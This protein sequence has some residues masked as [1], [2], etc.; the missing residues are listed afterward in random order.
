MFLFGGEVVPHT[1]H[2]TLILFGGK[3]KD[4]VHSWVL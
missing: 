2:I 1:W 3:S 4:D